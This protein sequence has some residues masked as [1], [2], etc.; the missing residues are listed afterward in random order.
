MAIGGDGVL[1]LVVLEVAV[2]EVVEGERSQR[3]FRGLRGAQELGARLLEARQGEEGVA[4]VEVGAGVAGQRGHRLVVGRERLFGLAVLQAGVALLDV[5]VAPLE[6]APGAEERQERRQHR[7]GDRGAAAALAEARL[8]EQQ[9]ERR[10]QQVP[11]GLVVLADEARLGLGALEAR[12]RGLDG[13]D[14]EVLRIRAQ[15]AAARLVAELG[16]QILIEPRG[17]VLAV[18]ILEV[19]RRRLALDELGHQLARARA[20]A[21]REDLDA[22]LGRLLR[23]VE[24]LA[25][26]VLAVREQ[27]DDLIARLAAL[28]AQARQHLARRGHRPADGGAAHR[29]VRRREVAPEE[30]HGI[31]VG[32]RWIGQGLAGEGHQADPVTGQ[33][34]HQPLE[35]ALGA[36]EPRR[37]HVL[38]QHRLREVE[39][40]HQIEAALLLEVGAAARLGARQRQRQQ[41]DREA[42]EGR[43]G[44]L[45]RHR[46][47]RGH[48]RDEHRVAEAGQGA[49]PPDERDGVGQH[50]GRHQQEQPQELGVRDPHGNLR[51]RPRRKRASSSTAPKAGHRKKG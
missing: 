30:L 9:E 8:D 37:V 3:L 26:G 13:L 36:L 18:P 27:E 44:H 22:E 17:D 28:G 29:H 1:V 5:R 25:L 20:D 32:G 12:Q 4:A 11:E 19:A 33:A 16:Q 40:H 43:A 34:V 48:A 21:H 2:A 31:V 49:P 38:G 15:V 50:E 39:R 14:P 46:G 47:D 6:R 42:D 7:R 51:R 35:L 23:R 45:A 24:R 10:Q 41:A